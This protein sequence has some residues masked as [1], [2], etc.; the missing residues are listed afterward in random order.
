MKKILTYLSMMILLYTFADARP[1][2]ESMIPNGRVNNCLTC[3]RNTYGD[4]NLFGETVEAK[5]LSTGVVDWSAVF[6]E[7]SDGDGFTNGE[8]LLDPEGTWTRMDSDPGNPADVTNPGDPD[9]FPTSIARKLEIKDVYPNPV[10]ENI[11]L[12]FEVLSSGYIQID[13]VD[14]TGQIVKSLHRSNMIKG[15]HRMT[16]DVNALPRGSYFIRYRHEESSSWLKF[17]K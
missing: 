17:V 6:A 13:I 5:G 12:E 3:H 4:R 15:V 11:N 14:I 9:D 1:G 10:I 8:E 16:F 2:R 7:D